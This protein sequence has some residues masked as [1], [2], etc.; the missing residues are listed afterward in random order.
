MD[1]AGLG[2]HASALAIGVVYVVERFI[3]PREEM[4]EQPQH[5]LRPTTFNQTRDPIEDAL[6]PLCPGTRLAIFDEVAR[7]G[8]LRDGLLELREECLV[9]GAVR[10]R[11]E[12]HVGATEPF[13]CSV[14]L[15]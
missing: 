5:Q 1:F 13:R 3:H 7:S 12:F 10:C 4:I 14:G 11:C 2:V 6:D 8:G 15:E 9:I